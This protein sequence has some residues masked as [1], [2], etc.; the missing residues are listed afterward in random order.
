MLRPLPTGQKC[1]EFDLAD[2]RVHVREMAGADGRGR[3]NDQAAPTAAALAPTP[4]HGLARE[5]GGAVRGD[6]GDRR[7]LV[8]RRRR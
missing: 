1:P 6:R 3:S 4:E 8:V 2:Q 7:V 5:F